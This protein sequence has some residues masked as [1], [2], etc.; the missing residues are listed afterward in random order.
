MQSLLLYSIYHKTIS[1]VAGQ[2]RPW[3]TY[4]WSD[5]VRRGLPSSPLDNV[6]CRTM[7]GVACYNCPWTAHT[8][9]QCLAWQ[10]YHRPF[11]S[12]YGLTTSGIKCHYCLLNRKHGWT[13]STWHAIISFR[14]QTC[15]DDVGSGMPQSPFGSTRGQTILGVNAIFTLRQHT[16]WD[17]VERDMPSSPLDNIHDRT[18]SSVRF[19]HSPWTTHTITLHRAWQAIIAIQQN[20]HG[21]TTSGMK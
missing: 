3:T 16:W 21:Q 10:C 13:M 19:H 1:G 14:L 5:N 11:G 2:N 15:T 17:D 20:T 4:T 8:V 12:K 9:E 6:H 18:T 7:L